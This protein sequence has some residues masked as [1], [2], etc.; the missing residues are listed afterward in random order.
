MNTNEP[1]DPKIEALTDQ[2]HD[3]IKDFSFFRFETSIRKEREG[4]GIFE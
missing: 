3:E 2:E 1:K 4:N